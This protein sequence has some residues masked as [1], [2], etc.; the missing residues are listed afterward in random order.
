ML[1]CPKLRGLCVSTSSFQSVFEWCSFFF[2]VRLYSNS[3]LKMMMM[4]FQK[5]LWWFWARQSSIVE[6]EQDGRLSKEENSCSVIWVEPALRSLFQSDAWLIYHLNCLLFQ[7]FPAMAEFSYAEYSL[8]FWFPLNFF[9]ASDLI[10][11]LV[12]YQS[13]C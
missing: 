7:Q 12:V 5:F 8:P 3:I 10:E 11:W 9:S 2:E 1:S 4:R 13:Q 6:K